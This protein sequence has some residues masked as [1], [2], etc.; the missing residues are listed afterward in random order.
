MEPIPKDPGMG[1]VWYNMPL[2][3]IFPQKSNGDVLRTHFF[4]LNSSPQVH[5]PFQRKTFQSFSPAIPGS[6]QKTIQGPQPPGPAVVGLL[7]H[8]RIIQRV[9]LRGYQSFN[10]SSRQQALQYSLGNSIDPYRL[11]SSNLYGVGPK[12]PIHIPMWE[13]SHTVKF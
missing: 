7:F 9:I 11:Y 1:H 13:F 3:T 2:C 12:G 4:H 6:Y 10:H 8:F 5:H